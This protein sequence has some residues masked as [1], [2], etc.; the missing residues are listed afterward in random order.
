M[1]GYFLL[2]AIVVWGT[3]K[4][5]FPKSLR[6]LLACFALIITLGLLSGYDS[7]LYPY[8]KDAWYFINPVASILVGYCFGAMS[9]RLR[10]ALR[11]LIVAGFILAVFHLARFIANPALITLPAT[12]VRALAGNGNFVVALAF[13]FLIATIGRWRE[14]LAVHPGIGWL[15]FPVCAAS[16]ALA[17]SRTLVI[18]ALVFW[19]ALR[20]LMVGARFIRLGAAALVILV[21]ITAVA[22]YLPAATEAEKKTFA[23]KLLRSVQELTISDYRDE[24]SIN[25]NF[26]G[27]ETAR[28]LKSFV[29]GGVPGWLGGRGFGYFVDLGIYLYLGEEPMRYIPVLHNGILYVLVKTGAVGLTLYLVSFCWLFRRG[30]RA[31]SASD[32][33]ERFAGRIVQGTVVVS[34]LTSWLISGPFN[35]TELVSV[36]LLLGFCLSIVTQ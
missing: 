4:S 8:L 18:V 19:L 7:E 12:E 2:L 23:G 31:S 28:A 32:Q 27:F 21:V 11:F 10:E 30:S 24:Q 34:L 22:N 6:V 15:V 33:N 36:L 13:A 16:V 5:S 9:P 17:Y 35:K 29:D 25:N 20:G 1:N 14:C 26:R 3:K